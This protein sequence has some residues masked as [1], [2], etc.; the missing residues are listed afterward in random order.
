[1][2]YKNLF[3]ISTLSIFSIT[4]SK[5]SSAL[6]RYVVGGN[7]GYLINL[8]SMGAAINEVPSIGSDGNK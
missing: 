3:I 1:M 4:Y 6:T 8:A 5:M 2:N 7:G